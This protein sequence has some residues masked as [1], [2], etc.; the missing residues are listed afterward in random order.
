[1]KRT[2]W[3]SLLAL[4]SCW[5]LSRSAAQQ[6][7]VLD[8]RE[9]LDF[10]ESK[11]RPLLLKQCMDCHS[12]ESELNGGLSLDSRADWE[13]GGDS[14]PAIDLNSWDKSLLWKAVEYRNP[15][16]RMPPDG[17]LSERDLDTL[18][19]WLESGALDPRERTQVSTKKQIGLPVSEAKNHW[20]YRP[21]DTALIPPNQHAGSSIDAFL[22]KQ[23]QD[24]GLSDLD[25]AS[26]DVLAQ[27]LSVDLL[28]TRSIPES[29]FAK[30]A[31]EDSVD[32]IL[33]SP[34][35]GE[36]FAR[37]WM[38]LVRFAES[39]TLRG[40]VVHDAWRYR[41]YLID[42]F[43]QDKP[44][45]LFLQE[46]LAGD[47]MQS[48]DIRIRQDQWAAT[49]MLAL[50]DTNLEEQDKKQLEMDYIDEQLD[51]IGKAIFGQTLGC[52]RCH[53]HKFDPIPTKDYYALASIL[54]SSVAIEH[55]N[56]SQWVRMPL[57][58]PSEQ[59]SDF[60]EAEK[61]LKSIKKELDAL[62]KRVGKN[63][64][65]GKIVAV[66]QL[67]GIVIDDS[68]AEKRGNWT[69]SS[70]IAAYLETGYL[71]D[72]HDSTM[73]K[74]VVFEP[75]AIPPGRYLIRVS[76]APGENRATNTRV[77]VF[78][79]DGEDVV[80]INQ[81]VTPKDGLWHPIGEYTF[82]TGG[83]AAVEISTEMANG[84]VIAD[85]VQ[86]LSVADQASPLESVAIAD[87]EPEVELKDRI[88]SMEKNLK[89]YEKVAG[90]RPMVVSLRAS[91]EPVDL[92]VHVRGSVHQLGEQSTRG[93]LTCLSFDEDI[94][95]ESKSDGR[96]ELARW[97]TSSK[98]PLTARVYVNRVWKWL[99]G[100]GLVRTVDNFGTTG[101]QPT[102]P[103]LLD[104]LTTQFIEHGWSTKWLVREIVTSRAYQLASKTTD[105][106]YQ[107]DPENRYYGRANVR[108]LS[109]EA[110]RDTVL[111][112]SGELDGNI[113]RDSVVPASM[114]EDY[115][116]QHSVRYRSVYGPW[117]R[118]S[119]PELFVEF[120]GANPS[121]SSG[122]RS[123]ST[124]S[125]QA[126]LMLNSPWISTR[127]TKIASR[128][129]ASTSNQDEDARIEELFGWMLSRRPSNEEIN[130]AKSILVGG[131]SESY[132]GLVHQL[133]SSLDFR[134]VE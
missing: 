68:K 103:E 45:D 124:V 51:V 80:Q 106:D 55:S 20:A 6:A 9:R 96:L 73:I 46:Q 56:V 122:Q 64:A 23:R 31:Y 10:F 104:W 133:M 93:F 109:P 28:G 111:R 42:S 65:S 44:I 30:L 88:A 108:R 21:V 95:I 125:G 128:F 97:A 24:A 22:Q 89:E 79:A 52:A 119:L 77:K 74:S 69:N 126:L 78:S 7:D 132:V 19:Q 25:I 115:R 105:A 48:D 13:T 123:R 110:I 1:M 66:S 38:D 16:L 14:G 37:H 71:H 81:R 3:I 87:P 118:N 70:S 99:M 41:Q 83:R 75:M 117:F 98:N 86:F 63:P 134:F 8:T 4:M 90:S 11:V 26:P 35:F 100:T 5:S 76:Y 27:R 47:L 67:P 85:G 18:R 94:R 36:H 92:K 58:L 116:F 49:S 127:A 15:K 102:H 50:G 39:I 84:H 29:G 91:K 130:W 121:F 34:Q 54:K 131:S 40:F 32:Q 33:A 114:K 107:L 43:N 17:K 82:E 113:L 59:E 129:L 120:D 12:H 57:P 53:D 62:K 101:E 2:T 112:L 61:N 60:N 72:S